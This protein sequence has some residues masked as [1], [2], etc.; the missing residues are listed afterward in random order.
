ML[1]GL[2]TVACGLLVRM[3]E[4]WKSSLGTAVKGLN[5]CFASVRRYQTGIKHPVLF[6]GPRPQSQFTEPSIF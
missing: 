1:E 5:I 4:C 6:T 3:N 2:N